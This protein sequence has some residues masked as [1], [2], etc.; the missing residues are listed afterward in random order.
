[1][2]G[3]CQMPGW[4]MLWRSHMSMTLPLTLLKSILVTPLLWSS[5]SQLGPMCTLSKVGRR[6]EDKRKNDLPLS[7][8][9][10]S[11]VV[12]KE[13]KKLFLVCSHLVLLSTSPMTQ[14]RRNQSNEGTEAFTSTSPPQSMP[15]QPHLQCPLRGWGAWGSLSL[16]CLGWST[17]PLYH[18]KGEIKA[19]WNDSCPYWEFVQ[20]KLKYHWNTSFSWLSYAFSGPKIG[21]TLLEEVLTI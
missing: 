1:M 18:R 6:P 4:V 15:E 8:E 14:T 5:T 7:W 10:S 9:K 21:T 11:E 17:R 16:R 19:P 3:S 20:C 13:S 2:G 12:F